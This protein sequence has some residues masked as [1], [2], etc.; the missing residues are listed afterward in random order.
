MHG[1]DVPDILGAL[2]VLATLLVIWFAWQTV[3]EAR[4]ATGEERNA[5]SELRSLV[6]TTRSLVEQARSAEAEADR[7]A[8]DA[9][10]RAEAAAAAAAERDREASERAAARDREVF[11]TRRWEQVLQVG[12]VVEDMFWRVAPF[13]DKPAHEVPG[14]VWMPQRNSLRHLLVGLSEAI[15]AG[16]EVVDAATAGQAFGGCARARAEVERELKRVEDELTALR[17]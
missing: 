17:G 5:V 9:A 13:R 11:L 10:D 15:P 2:T 4:K 3:R 14:N 12:Q 6:Q 1:N 8:R 16:E 7:R